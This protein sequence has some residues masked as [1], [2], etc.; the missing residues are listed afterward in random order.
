[1]KVLQ[2]NHSDNS[3]FDTN[4]GHDASAIYFPQQRLAKCENTTTVRK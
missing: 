4:A 3:K 2:G 1:V